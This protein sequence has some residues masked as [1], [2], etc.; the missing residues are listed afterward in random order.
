MIRINNF[1][2]VINQMN[3]LKLIA[4]ALAFAVALNVSAER[5]D[6]YKGKPS[7]TLSEAWVNFSESN[8][9]LEKL[10]AGELGNADIATVHELTYTL[11]NAVKKINESLSE[12]AETLEE[13]HVASETFDAATVKS[14]GEVYL[15]VS[16][17]FE[18]RGQGK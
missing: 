15:S 17:G 14:K 11:E 18:K 6:H 9:R 16:K 2:G 13:V 5:V 12:V 1:A 7:N 4:G 10:L 3:V 8:R